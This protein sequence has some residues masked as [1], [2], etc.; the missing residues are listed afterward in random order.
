MTIKTAIAQVVSIIEDVAAGDGPPFRLDKSGM[1]SRRRQFSVEVLSGA[2]VVPTNEGRHVVD[3]D[4]VLAYEAQKAASADRHTRMVDII[5]DVQ[6][7]TDALL[8]DA[9]WGRPSSGIHRLTVP[10]REAI[11]YS[12]DDGGDDLPHLVRFSFPLEHT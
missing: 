12:I 9:Q 6:N 5:T 7:V 11:A 1:P 10:G 2:Q 4:V 8:D 3:V